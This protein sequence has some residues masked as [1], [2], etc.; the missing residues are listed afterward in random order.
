MTSEE[1]D[2]ELE[3]IQEDSESR[4]FLTPEELDKMRELY[5]GRR[6]R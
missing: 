6:K 2:R 1:K 3:K 5:T 4:G